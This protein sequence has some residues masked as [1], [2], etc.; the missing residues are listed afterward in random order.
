MMLTTQTVMEYLPAF[1]Y[2]VRDERQDTIMMRHALER[3]IERALT[4]CNQKKIPKGLEYEI[5]NM[6]VGEFL[7]IKK[8]TGGLRDPECGIEFPDVIKQFTEGDTNVS[9]NA[10]SKNDEANFEKMIDDMRH[11]DPYVLEHYRRL[12]W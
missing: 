4:F 3:A 1:G 5:I 12:H 9:A 11:G 7:Y 2:T 6:A 8:I 10:A